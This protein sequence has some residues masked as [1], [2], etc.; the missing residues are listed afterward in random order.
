MLIV[1]KLN[2]VMLN[3]VML[4]VAIFI[5]MLNVAMPSV[6]APFYVHAHDLFFNQVATFPD[7]FHSLIT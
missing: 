7:L 6:M 5:V 1:V 2:A 3:V 4:S